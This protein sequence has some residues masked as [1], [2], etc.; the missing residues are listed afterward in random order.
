MLR[1]LPNFS[2][3]PF[4]FEQTPTHTVFSFV[5]FF[6]SLFYNPFG[7]YRNQRMLLCI[8]VC[9]WFTFNTIFYICNALLSHQSTLVNLHELTSVNLFMHVFLLLLS[10]SK[11]TSFLLSI[12][13]S[14]SHP[15][16]YWSHGFARFNWFHYVICDCMNACQLK[17]LA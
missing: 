7:A 12:F 2:L 14:V 11:N 1:K 13:V 15:F 9:H 16:A 4:F 17:I 10:L 6:V 5:L 3:L 8:I